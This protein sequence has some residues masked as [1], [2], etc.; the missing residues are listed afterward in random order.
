MKK[1]KVNNE[2]K[3]APGYRRRALASG[4]EL[5]YL[6]PGKYKCDEVLLFTPHFKQ[7]YY[8]TYILL[9]KNSHKDNS[10]WSDYTGAFLSR[11]EDWSFLEEGK[12]YLATKFIKVPSKSRHRKWTL[13]VLHV[14]PVFFEQY[15]IKP[16]TSALREILIDDRVSVHYDGR[17]AE[18]RDIKVEKEGGVIILSHPTTGRRIAMILSF[19]SSQSSPKK[20]EKKDDFDEWSKKELQKI[21]QTEEKEWLEKA[22]RNE[23]CIAREGNKLIF[24]REWNVIKEFDL[25]LFVEK[26]VPESVQLFSDISAIKQTIEEKERKEWYKRYQELRKKFSKVLILCPKCKTQLEWRDT[27]EKFRE[28][29]KDL[30]CPKCG[31]VF[32]KEVRVREK[33]STFGH[34]THYETVIKRKTIKEPLRVTLLEAFDRGLIIINPYINDRYELKQLEKR[35]KEELEPLYEQLSQIYQKIHNIK[36]ELKRNLIIAYLQE[37]GVW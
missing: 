30:L 25:K 6:L 1:E 8:G 5:F 19:E 20:E 32:E 18:L 31:E 4:N 27:K 26:V 2:N 3:Y 12:L 36:D 10:E 29:L 15:H 13:I 11:R 34:I 35:Y 33:E 7:G 16:T 37:T 9:E 23:V 28:G 24:H 22:R 14:V 21:F 17:K